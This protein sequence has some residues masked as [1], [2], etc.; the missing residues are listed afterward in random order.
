MHPVWFYKLLLLSCPV[1]VVMLAT[2]ATFPHSTIF[3]YHSPFMHIWYR[4]DLLFVCLYVYS[5]HSRSTWFTSTS[6]MS[7]SKFFLYRVFAANFLFCLVFCPVVSLLTIVHLSLAGTH[8][9]IGTIID[10]LPPL[11]Q[12]SALS[13][14]YFVLHTL[15][16]HS[17][18]AYRYMGI[19]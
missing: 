9:W 12:C 16:T 10:L 15:V 13:L 19:I 17:F 3:F 18:N 8:S 14:Q 1:F 5:F 4:C 7:L 11:T 2:V 6:P